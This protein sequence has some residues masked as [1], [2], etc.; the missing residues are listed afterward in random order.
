MTNQLPS[1]ISGIIA[2]SERGTVHVT[3][4]EIIFRLGNLPSAAAV[5]MN[6][7]FLAL[8]PGQVTTCASVWG[9]N[10]TVRSGNAACESITVTGATLVLDT[11]ATG[12]IELR[13]SGRPGQTYS[14]ERSVDLQT[15]TIWKSNLPGPTWA[16]IIP[17]GP[18]A[19]FYRL[20]P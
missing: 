6:V 3:D 9:E 4:N 2:E 19:Q 11:H 13:L 8:R 16:E 7:S 12:A 15:W 10:E 20:S 18:R 17:V 14:I 5:E 1:G